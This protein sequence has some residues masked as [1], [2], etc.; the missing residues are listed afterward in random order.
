M[1][2]PRRGNENLTDRSESLTDL[3]HSILFHKTYNFLSK[4]RGEYT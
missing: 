3:S 2:N 4:N 1:R